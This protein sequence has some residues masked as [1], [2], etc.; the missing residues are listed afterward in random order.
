[1]SC[2]EKK[3][4][5]IILAIDIEFNFLNMCHMQRHTYLDL[6][7]TYREM[8]GAASYTEAG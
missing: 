7:V 8:T 5:L 4:F 3:F 6:H 1:M 2:R